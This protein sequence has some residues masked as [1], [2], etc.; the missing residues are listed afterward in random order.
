ML[1]GSYDCLISD[2]HWVTAPSPGFKVKTSQSRCEIYLIFKQAV[3]HIRS[4]WCTCSHFALYSVL[5][6][7]VIFFKGVNGEERDKRG[8]NVADIKKLHN[9]K[10]KEKKFTK[11][12]RPQWII[13]YTLTH[14]HPWVRQSL[15]SKMVETG[16]PFWDRWLCPCSFF[17][18]P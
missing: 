3:I 8:N 18:G 11:S 17:A 14:S 15:S 4:I 5:S 7:V 10:G 6:T 13:N 1:E 16:R 9:P 12:G 2:S